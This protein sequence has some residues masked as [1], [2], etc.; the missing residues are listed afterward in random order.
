LAFPNLW[1]RTRRMEP[2]F[3]LPLSHPPRLIRKCEHA[4]NRVYSHAP[5]DFAHTVSSQNKPGWTRRRE[6]P[7]RRDSKFR[8]RQKRREEN[9]RRTNRSTVQNL[10]VF[11]LVARIH[12][13]TSPIIRPKRRQR[14]RDDRGQVVSRADRKRSCL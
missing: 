6:R 4:S 10:Y 12:R 5:F 3:P 2:P 1:K 9:G 11:S 7:E 13:L 14:R 8:A